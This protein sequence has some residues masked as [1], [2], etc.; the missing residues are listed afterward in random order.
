MRQREDVSLWP[1][2]ALDSCLIGFDSSAM[3]IL[4]VPL[5][6]YMMCV[7]MGPEFETV[8]YTAMSLVYGTKFILL[9]V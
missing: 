5:P 2:A 3:P 7:F 1:S 6:L 8:A 4:P 9:F